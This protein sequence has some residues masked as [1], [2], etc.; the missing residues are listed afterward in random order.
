MRIHLGLVFSLAIAAA[1]SGAEQLNYSPSLWQAPE[2]AF[3]QQSRNLKDKLDGTQWNA[4]CCK[5]CS[6]GKASGNSCIKRTYTCHKGRGC[7]CDG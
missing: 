2:G 7:A 1:S 3:S 5:V 6:K 4:A